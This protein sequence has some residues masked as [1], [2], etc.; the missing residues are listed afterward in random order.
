MIEGLAGAIEDLGG[1]RAGLDEPISRPGLAA[2]AA[3]GESVGL[4]DGGTGDGD[5]GAVFQP[6][7]GD[8]ILLV[9]VQLQGPA[10]AHGDGFQVA[11]GELLGGL[12]L[13]RVYGPQAAVELVPDRVGAVDHQLGDARVLQDRA[14]PFWKN[15]QHHVEREHQSSPC[16]RCRQ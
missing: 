10:D 12:R 16:S 9:H 3:D 14:Q 8:G 7:I 5:A 4:G 15:R 1:E 11:R 6:G 13:V 2:E